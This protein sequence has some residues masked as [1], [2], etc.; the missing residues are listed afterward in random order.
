MVASQRTG[1]SWS[2]RG[3]LGVSAAWCG[4]MLSPLVAAQQ[5][6]PAV[7]R[8]NIKLGIDNFAVRA[9]GW[10]AP[11]L[12]DYAASLQID[13]LFISDLDAFESLETPALTAVRQRAADRGLQI[14]VGTWSICPTSTTFR[15]T[16]GTAEEHLRLGLRVARDLGS[17]VLRVILGNGADRATPGGI[18][19]RIADTVK[20]CQAC[21][22]QAQDMGVKIAVENHA[23]DMQAR[24]LVG[25]IE[26]AG[27]DFVGANLDSGNAVWTLEDPLANL[28]LLGPYALTTSLRDS[29][30]WPSDK[31]VTVQWTAM[32]DG[33]LDLA[34]Y[35]T[36]F[37]QLCPQTPVHIETISGFNREFPLWSDD[38]WK[39]WPQM[40]AQELARFLALARQGTPRPAW[41]PPEGVD[42]KKA[43]QDYQKEQV[44][45]SIRFCKQQLGLG[46]R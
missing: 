46:L 21:R 15:K 12:I 42:R 32:G 18:E 2:R 29:A 24:E 28:E 16:W 7:P 6:A 1:E 38:F 3:F 19:A 17:P 5:A 22:S 36:R 37:A 26:A 43:E 30:I 9:L 13:S 44:E 40:K 45:R 35:F 4:A 25:L 8:R 41:S 23:G 31:G 39:A 11:A 14:H 20:V 33:T 34:A 10:K 27:R